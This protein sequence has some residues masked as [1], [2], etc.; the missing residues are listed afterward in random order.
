MVSGCDEEAKV[1]FEQHVF[2]DGLLDSWCPEDG[3][4]R[5]YMELVCV[6]LSKNPYMTVAQKHEHIE[7]YRTYFDEKKEALLRLIAGQQQEPDPP[8]IN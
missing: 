7:W 3:P 4:V 2:L 5:V 6:G 1:S 8:L